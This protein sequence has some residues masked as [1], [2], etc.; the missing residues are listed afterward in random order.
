MGIKITHL[1]RDIANANAIHETQDGAVE[2]SK[3][4]GRRADAR[5]TGIFPQGHVF[6][7]PSLELESHAG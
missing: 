2:L 4:T 7:I 5:L 1:S 3:E 6:F